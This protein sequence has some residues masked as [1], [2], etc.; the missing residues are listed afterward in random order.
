MGFQVLTAVSMKLRVFWDVASCSHVEVDR[1]FRGEYGVH[2]GDSLP[3]WWWQYTP[4][5]RRSPSTWLY[6]AT[7]Q[8]TL[9]FSCVHLIRPLTFINRCLERYYNH[10]IKQRAEGLDILTLPAKYARHRVSLLRPLLSFSSK[11]M[12]R[13]A[14]R[15]C[16]LQLHQRPL[17]TRDMKITYLTI[18]WLTQSSPTLTWRA[19][20]SYKVCRQVPKDSV[21]FIL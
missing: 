3:W 9:N 5:K 1:P 13:V 20:T 17:A 6:G 14:R 18:W 12:L 2:Q 15:V 10:V 11:A 7:S 16:C 21:I 19:S 8:K 4:M